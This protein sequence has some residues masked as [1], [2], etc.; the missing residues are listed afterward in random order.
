ML[1]QQSLKMRIV[2]SNASFSLMLLFTQY[3]TIWLT[4]YQQLLSRCIAY[5][6]FLCS[7]VTS[8]TD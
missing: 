6:G 4:S 8:A 1:Q 2:G 3:K 5:H 7:T